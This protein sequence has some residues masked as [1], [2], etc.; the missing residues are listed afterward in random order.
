[1]STL[2]APATHHPTGLATRGMAGVFALSLWGFLLSCVFDPA[3]KLFGLKVWFFLLCW[4]AGAARLMA[5]RKPLQVPTGLL[6]YT[7]TFIFIPF[8]SIAQYYIRGGVEPF[9][10]LQMLKGYILITFALLLAMTRTDL[11]DRMATTLTLL[12]ISI[13]AT[14]I[15]IGVAPELETVVYVFGAATGIVSIDAGRD[16]GSDVVLSQVYFVTS[17]MLAMAI[18]HYYD[19]ARSATARAVRTRYAILVAVNVVAM[20]LAGT[21]N[22]ILVAIVLPLSLWFIHSRRKAPAS[23]IAAA[24]ALLA[25]YAFNTELAAFFDPQEHS[26][27]A[28]LNLINDYL[29][30]FSSVPVLLFGQG[31]GAFHPWSAPKATASIA[32]LTYFEMIRNFG[33]FGAIVMFGLLVQPIVRAFGRGGTARDATLAVGYAYYMLMCMTNPNMFSSMGILILSVM[34]A[35]SYSA[36]VT[37]LKPPPLRPPT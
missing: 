14:A 35:T 8:A 15:A 9:D 1:M 13:I 24:L 17:P 34:L 19:R 2:F 30:I 36:R 5:R 23:V 28:K 26:N 18:A 16:Y 20:V 33:L 4:L 21:R 12:A 10:G 27:S 6:I 22:N 7:F 37:P 31:L 11:F 29:E 25:A 3:D 32:E